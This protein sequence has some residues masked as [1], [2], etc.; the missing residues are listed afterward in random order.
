M[1]KARGCHQALRA[2]PASRQPPATAAPAGH[3]EAQEPPVSPVSPI[4]SPQCHQQPHRRASG[5]LLH[6]RVPAG[7]PQRQQGSLPHAGLGVLAGHLQQDAGGSALQQQLPQLRRAPAQVPQ[8]RGG[9]AARPGVGVE[10]QASQPGHGAAQGAGW[11]GRVAGG[12]AHGEAGCSGGRAGAP[13][14]PAPRES[15]ETGGRSAAGGCLRTGRWSKRR[16]WA[17]RQQPA[18]LL[19]PRPARRTQRGGTRG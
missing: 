6:P 2:P 7:S 9:V 15:R 10:Q 11:G 5:Y 14:R 8:G 18:G 13:R 17:P 12:V 4:T 16:G 19:E 3:T 1:Q